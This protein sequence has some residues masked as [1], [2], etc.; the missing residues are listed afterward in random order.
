MMKRLWLGMMVLALALVLAACGG[1]GG[2][3]TPAA[4]AAP[5]EEGYPPPTVAITPAQ[6]YPAPRPTPTLPTGYP[7][8]GR[9]WLIKP[10]GMQCQEP[11][12]NLNQ[13]VA[14]L[15]NNGI[16]VLA[17]QMTSLAVCEACEVCP[18]SEHYRILVAPEQIEAAKRFGWEEEPR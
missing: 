2:A 16:L 11:E 12:S 1:G 13:E 8:D 17:S 6:G 9:V 14:V 7:D 10:V 4:T 18:T 15:Q 5:V 3:E